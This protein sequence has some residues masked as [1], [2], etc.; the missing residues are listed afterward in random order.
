MRTFPLDLFRISW[1]RALAKADGASTGTKI[2]RSSMR[3]IAGSVSLAS[4]KM[5]D[6][7]VL[8]LLPLELIVEAVIW[9][10]AHCMLDRA[11]NIEVLPVPDG[12]TMRTGS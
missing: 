6:R 12:P 11:S 9:K 2:S 5:A 3:I 10:V 1:P 4:E 8:I 7:A